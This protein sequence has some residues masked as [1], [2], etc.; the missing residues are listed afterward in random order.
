VLEL[1]RRMCAHAMCSSPFAAARHTHSGALNPA[2]VHA[3]RPYCERIHHATVRDTHRKWSGVRGSSA[4]GLQQLHTSAAI[5]RTRCSLFASI[6]DPAIEHVEQH[7]E[8][9]VVRADALA[10][11]ERAPRR[12]RGRDAP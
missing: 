4:G 2:D 11:R 9:G 3:G 8:P 10:Q 12:A 7:T 5:A 1:V 6:T